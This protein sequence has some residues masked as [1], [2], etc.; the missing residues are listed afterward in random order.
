MLVRPGMGNIFGD[1]VDWVGG[2]VNTIT[3]PAVDL[4][5]AVAVWG[6][7]HDVAT[8]ALRD[9]S[10][11]TVGKV[12]C[13]TVETA[14]ATATYEGVNMA[15]AAGPAVNNGGVV[16]TVGWW[17][18]TC[19]PAIASIAFAFPR[20][21][22]GDDFTT[23]WLQ[24]VV[25]RASDAAAAGGFSDASEAAAALFTD[26][27]KQAIQWLTDH[28]GSELTQTA[29]G[30]ADLLH[31]RE[32]AA[33]AA[34]N[35]LRKI[36]PPWSASDPASGKLLARPLNPAEAQANF[37]AALGNAQ[38]VGLINQYT[39]QAK[40]VQFNAALANLQAK[41]GTGGGGVGASAPPSSTIPSWLPFAMVG[42]FIMGAWI[43]TRKYL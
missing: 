22:Q 38:W 30:L 8:G 32:D 4:A 10:R 17:S 34:L 21:F 3:S 37:N 13:T 41:A 12:V 2:A 20:V 39:D 7:V 9:F 36:P 1:A 31:L 29:I 43:V 24:G 33:D 11:T 35:L 19:A 6:P 26:Q 18:K 14:F 23:A 27:T 28:A 15:L 25:K 42:G 40:Q 16:S 5:N